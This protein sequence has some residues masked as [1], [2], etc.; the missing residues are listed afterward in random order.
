[1]CVDYGALSKITIKNRFPIPRLGDIMDRFEGSTIFSQIHL[2]SGYHQVCVV[3]KDVYKTA[4]R[5]TFGLY[6]YLVV[7]FGLTNAP[8]TFN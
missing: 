7:P 5:T 4:F 6:E 2:K 1:M 8:A 3:P